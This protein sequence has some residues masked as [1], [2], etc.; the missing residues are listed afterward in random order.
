MLCAMP[1]LDKQVTQRALL[2]TSVVG[3][4]A[5]VAGGRGLHPVLFV[6]LV[7]GT[8]GAYAA[9]VAALSRAPKLGVRLLAG[10]ALILM[11]FV[12]AMPARSS[13]DVWA[14]VMYGRIVA[15]HHASP[16]T[17][18]PADYPS[19]PALQRVQVAFRD[20]GSVY[21]PAFTAVSAAGM[22]GCGSSP[23]CGR[24]F[25]QTLE[26]LAVLAAAWIVLHATGSRAAA[27]C[28]AFNPVLIASVVNGAHND[29]LVTLGIL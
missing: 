10:A 7:A 25:F 13:K 29:G 12:V 23:I 24:V 17:H 8:F 22:A 5:I 27:A 21:G 14:Y 2:A 6:V 4:A 9:L 16:Y 26:A 15:V 20:T 1:A 19:D 28:V 18:V 11:V 3:T